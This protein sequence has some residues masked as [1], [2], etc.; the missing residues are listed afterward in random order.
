MGESEEVA[1][2]WEE[3]KKHQLM[4]RMQQITNAMSLLQTRLVLDNNPTSM[5]ETVV[6]LT[7]PQHEIRLVNY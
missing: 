3:L 6:P 7:V 1:V 4:C 5:K 2:K